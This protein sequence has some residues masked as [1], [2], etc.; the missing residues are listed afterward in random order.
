[1][2]IERIL[3]KQ[4]D[5]ITDQHRRWNKQHLFTDFKNSLQRTEK[6]QLSNYLL[7]VLSRAV[8]ISLPISS[9]FFLRL[10]SRPH[11]SLSVHKPSSQ[12]PQCASAFLSKTATISL[13]HLI[14]FSSSVILFFLAIIQICLT[15]IFFAVSCLSSLKLCLHEVES[16]RFIG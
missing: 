15:R 10:G 11:S 12:F 8:R 4:Q 14:S 13:S 5:T 6:Y 16:R 7:P 9:S 3:Q 1:M 2:S